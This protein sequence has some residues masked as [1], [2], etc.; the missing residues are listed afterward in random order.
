MNTKK[1]NAQMLE[2]QPT[3][4]IRTIDTTSSQTIAKPNVSGSFFGLYSIDAELLFVHAT[5][6]GA[7][8]HQ[9]EYEK[10]H[11]MGFYVEPVLVLD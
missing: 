6:E 8:K 3:N 2:P 4:G 11:G 10:A 9:Y 7:K 1:V 5:R